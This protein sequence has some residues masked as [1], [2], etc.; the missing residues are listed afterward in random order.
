VEA[1]EPPGQPLERG[2]PLAEH[3]GALE[4]PGVARREHAGAQRVDRRARAAG[5]EVA[6]LADP[7]GVAGVRRVAARTAMG[8]AVGTPRARAGAGAQLGAQAL[9]ARAAAPAGPAASQS[10]TPVAS[11]SARAASASWCRRRNGP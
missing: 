6:R 9:A 4:L 11:A 3:G 2:Q 8:V 1:F 5:E 7:R 10:R